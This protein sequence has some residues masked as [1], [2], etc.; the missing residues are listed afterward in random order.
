MNT[1]VKSVFAIIAALLF[2][3]SFAGTTTV[4]LRLDSA[5]ILMG[6]LNTMHLEVIQDKGIKGEFPLFRNIREKGY[7]TLLNDTIELRRPT[8]VDTTE[9]GSGRIQIDY[10]VPVQVFDSGTYRLPEIVFL[11]GRD[12]VRSNS[13]IFSV[14]PVKVTADDPIS[15]M[16]GV[17]EPENSS[18]FDYLPDWLYRWWWLILLIIGLIAG[19]IWV[20][21][22]YRKDGTILPKKIETPPYELAMERLRRLK[23][24]NLWQSGQEKEFY[25]VLT[26]ILRSYLDGRFGIRAMEMTSRDIMEKLSEDPSMREN[27]GR[28]RQIL[29]MADFVKFAM[30]RPLPDD[31]VKSFDNALAFVESTK[32]V[33]NPELP[34]SSQDSV[35][36]EG[37]A[38]GMPDAT[39]AES[40]NKVKDKKIK[41]KHNLKVTFKNRNKRKGGES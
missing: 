17:A 5:T 28:M 41:D 12:S 20:W 24:R 10:T 14:V 31:N 26:D 3:S 6:N 35:S 16:T 15:P 36:T 21:L 39:P 13:V 9:I 19:G 30:V 11:A 25:T 1:K 34:R 8:K 7:A 29:D 37:N 22:R 23:S 2:F 18:I 40:I 27:R 33:E 38:S 4:K 32:P